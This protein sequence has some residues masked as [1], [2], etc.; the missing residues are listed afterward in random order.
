M[1]ASLRLSA[2]SWARPAWLQSIPVKVRHPSLIKGGIS[3]VKGA[4]PA[5]TKLKCQNDT[6]CSM[7]NL[8]TVFGDKPRVRLLEALLS[9]SPYNFTRGELAGDAGLTRRSANRV[10]PELEQLNL[11]HEV[12]PGSQP[13]YA[14]N[15]ESKLFQI[16][17]YV[18]HA[19]GL[20]IDEDSRPDTTDDSSEMFRQA[21]K[22][23][24]FEN[25]MQTTTVRP[26][27]IEVPLKTEFVTNEEE[28]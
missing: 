10:F 20:A 1:A 22:E 23:V 21:I 25:S 2:S 24:L 5:S 13:Y 26:A 3:G 11:V 18:D 12:R 9:L 17:Q 14:A 6:L 28:T 15:K 19:I 4:C 16:L 27:Q 7:R 8:A